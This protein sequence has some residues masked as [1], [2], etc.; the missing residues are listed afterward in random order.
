MSKRDL[1]RRVL[2]KLPTI[3]GL[4]FGEIVGEGFFSH[5]YSGKFHGKDVA[6]KVIERGNDSLMDKE[7]ELLRELNGAPHTIQLLKVF[8]VETTILVFEFIPSIPSQHFLTHNS[9]SRMRRVLYY[10]LQ[11]VAEAHRRNIIH[12]DI[13]AANIMIYPHFT[14]LKLIDWGCGIHISD[15]LSPKEGSRTCRSPEMLLGSRNY[16]TGGDRWAIGVLIFYVLTKGAV[17]WKSTSTKDLLIKMSQYYGLK[18]FEDLEDKYHLEIPMDARF[19]MQ[20][21]PTKT[22]E[23]AI[24]PSM[25]RLVD[26]RLLSLMNGLMAIDPEKRLTAEQALN[27]SYFMVRKT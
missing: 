15:D 20:E 11:A 25:R 18:P 22:L 7:I 6:I 24:D 16:G 17:P 23:S 10:L 21:R 12:R 13:K 5:V 2:S 4:T 27:H 8:E 9:Q 3:E 19:R 1:K 14:D 26:D